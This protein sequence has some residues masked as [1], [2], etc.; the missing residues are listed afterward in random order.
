MELTHT[1][2]EEELEQ[3]HYSTQSRPE[4]QDRAVAAQDFQHAI[5][6]TSETVADYDRTCFSC[7]IWQRQ[8]SQRNKRNDITDTTQR[9][10][11]RLVESPAV[12]GARSYIGLCLAA[13]NEEKRR[14]GEEKRV[15]T[16]STHE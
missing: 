5:Q 12:S 13:K 4:P 10:L 8:H 3:C 16:I 9:G 11:Y 1:R 14:A 2:R 6:K 7:G 15:L